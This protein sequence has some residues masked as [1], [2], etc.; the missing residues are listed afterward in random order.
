MNFIFHAIDYKEAPI[1]SLVYYLAQGILDVGIFL[2]MYSSISRGTLKISGIPIYKTKR[3]LKVVL[4]YST[5]CMLVDVL[6]FMGI[7]AQSTAFY[8]IMDMGILGL[9]GLWAI[10]I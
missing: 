8:E 7:G 2:F 4:I 5:W 10:F 9:G 3:L 6:I 1:A